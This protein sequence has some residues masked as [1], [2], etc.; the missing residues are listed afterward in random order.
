MKEAED[1]L[2]EKRLEDVPIVRDFPEV[3]LEDLPGILPT[4][5]VEF[6]IDL[7]LGATPVA[8]APY[9]L[10]PS[11][12][13]ELADQ[14]QELSDKGFIRPSFS[15]WGA[16]VLFV[17]K[18][19]ESFQMCIDYRELNKLTVKNRYPL[20][21]IDDLFDQL[22]GSSVYS[23]I[24]LRSGYHQLRFREEDIPKTAFRTRYGHYEFQVMPF[25]LT[26]APA[27]FMDLMNRVCKPYLDKFLIIFIDDILIYSKN[28]EDHEEHLKLILELLKK[29]E[30]YAKFS[31]C[32]FWIPKVQFLRHM[33][34]SKGIHGEKE[35]AE[36]QLIKKSYVAYPFWPCLKD[37]NT[38]LFI[39]MLRIK[40]I[41]SSSLTH[42][43]GFESSQ[44]NPRSSDEALKPENL[45]VEDVRQ[46]DPMEKLMRLY[47]KE[48]VTQHG[49]PVS[50]IS[51][52]DGRLMSLFWKALNEALEVGDAQLTGPEIVHET[53]EKIVQIKSRIQAAC[54]RQ[55]SYADLKRKPM[56]FQV[57]DRVILSVSPWKGVKCLPDE[58]L[59]ISLDGLRIDDKLYFV[60]EPV[61]IMDREIKQLKRSRILIIKNGVIRTK[62]YDELSVT[63]KIQFDCDM[64][65]INIILQGTSLTKQEREYKLYDAFDKFTHIKGESLHTYYLRFTQLINDI[66]IYK[67][68][69]EQFQDNKK[70]LNSLPSEWSK[71]VTDVKLVKNL[72][73]SNYD[74][75]HAYLK[76]HELH[77]NEVRLMREHNQDPFALVEKAMLAEAQEAGQMLDEEQLAFLADLG[78]PASQAQIII[79]HNAVFQIED[80]DTYDSDC[81]D[82]STTQAVLMANISNYGSDI[83]SEV[84][85]F[86][87]YLNDMDNQKEESR[88][89]MSEKEK[90]PEAIKQN[91]SL[92]PIDYEKL[93]RLTEYF[94]TR[95]TSQQEFLGE[96]AFWLRLSS[97]TIESSSTPPVKVEVPSELPKVS[98]VNK[99]LK[100]LKFQLTQFDSMVKKR[101]TPNALTEEYFKKNVLKAQ[102]QDKDT[103]ICKLKDTIK[104][105]RKNNKE[106]I[107]DH[108]RCVC[109]HTHSS[110][111]LVG[112]SSPNPTTSNLKLHNCRRSKQPFI[113]E[114]YPVDM[115]VNQRT[116]AELF[117]APIEGYA[118][119]IVVPPILAKHFKLKHILIN[120]MT[121]DQFFRLEKDNPHDHISVILKK[122]PEKLGDPRKF[123]IPCGYCELKCKALA[124]L[125]GKFTFLVD[126]VIVD[127]KS[128][129]R[130]SLFLGR[131]FL[132]TARALIDILTTILLIPFPDMFIDEHTLDY[133]SPPLY[134]DVDDDLV[135]LESDNGDV[136]DDL[137]DSKEDK[138]KESKL[139]IDELNPPRS[140]DFL[141]SPEY[142][143]VLCED[144]SKVDALP[145]TNKE[146]KV[147][148]PGI[149]IHENLSAVTVQ[150]I[151]DKNV[152]KIS[153]SNASLII[154][155][156]NPPLYELPFHKEVPGPP[157]IGFMRPFG[158]PVTI[159]NTLDSLGKF[160]GKVDEG[161]LVGY[162][163][164]SKAFR[165]FNS[166]TR[167]VQE[168]L[169]VNFLENKPNITGS[170]PT[171]LFDIDSLTRTM[172]YEPVSV[173]NQTNPSAS[174]QDKFDAEK[175]REEINQ[176]NVLFS[177]WSSGSTNPHNNDGDVAFDR[178][179]HDFDAKKPESGVILSPS[180]SA[181][182][183]KQDDKTKKEAKG[184]I[185]TV[186]QNTS[187]S[188]NP[189]SV[190]GPSN[191]TA[192]QTH[193]KSSFDASQLFDD[194]AMPEL[195]DITYSDDE[196]DVGAEADFNNLETSITVNPIP[197]TR[198]HKDHP[199]SQIIGDLS[200]TTQTRSM[201]RVVKD[202]GGLSQMFNDDFHTCMFACFLSQEEPKRV[203]QALKDPR[204]EDPDHPDKVY[205]VVKALYG[206]HQAPRAWYETL[207]NYLLE[208]GFQRGKIDQT[209]FIK[210]QKGDILLVKQK[211]DRI[212]ISQDKYVAEILRKFGL[213]EGK[214]ASTLIDTEKPLL[215]DPDGED[216]DVHTYRSMI[217][218]LMY[219]TSSRPD[220]VFAFWNSV[221]IKQV[222]DITRLQA[223]VDKKKVVV[224]EAAIREV[225]RL[226]D[227]EGVDCLPNEEIFTKRVGKGF[228][229]V[230][231]PLF[232]GMLVGQEIDEG[233]NEEVHVEDVTA[234]DVAQGEDT[235]A[236]GDV[237]TVSQEP[238]IPSPTPPT[239]SPQPPQ[240]L[241]SISQV[242][243]T[244][245]QLSQA[246]PQPQPQPQQAV[247]FP[248]SLFQ[249]ALDAC[250]AL[251]R[252][253][254]HL[255]LKRVGTSQ[256]IDTSND[257]VIDDESNQGRIIDEM[258]KDD[259]VALMDDKEEDK[260]DKEA[261][262]VKIDQVQGRQAES[263]A[264]IYRID[265]DYASKV[266]SMQEDEPAEVQEVVDVVTTAK[267]ITGVVTTASETVT[268]ASI[269]ISTVEPQVP[270]ATITAALEKRKGIMVEEP[271]P[272]K[273]KQQIEMGEEYARKLHAKI[274]KDIDWDVAIDHVKLKAKEDPALDYFKGMSHDDIRPIF[275]AKFNSNIEFFLKTKEQIEEEENRA[276]QKLSAAKQKLM[277]LDNAVE[278]RLMLL[279][280]IN[281]AEVIRTPNIVEHE[282]RAIIEMADNHT[283][284][285]LLQAPTEGY[286]E[287]IVIP[288]INAD[289][290]EIKMNLLQ[291]VQ[292]NLYHGFEREN[293]HT[294][295][296]D[297]NRITSTL[298]FR[299]VP[300][301]VIKLMM[302]LY[303]LKGNAR[304][305]YDKEPP[306]SILTWEDLTFGEAWERFKE[307]LRA[308]PHHG[309]TK[310][311]QIDTFCNG[312]N[313][314]D[315]DSLNA[316]AGGNLLSK[317]TREALQ[318]IKNK[319]KVHY[320]RNKADVSRMNT[321]FREN[322]NKLDDRIDKLE[323]KI[324]TLVDI[325]AKK[326]VAPAPVKVVEEFCVT[327]DGAHAYYNCPNTDSNQPT[328]C[329]ATGTYN[330]LAPQNR[331]NNFM[332]PPGFAL[333]Q[334]STSGTLPSNTIPNPKGE[335]K[336]I[337]TRSGVAYEG[338][339][340]PTPKKVV[341]QETEE[342]TDKEQTNFQ[343]STAHIQPSVTPITKPDV[344]KTLPKTN[345]P[346]PS[347][348]NDQKLREKT[349]NQM[350][351]FFQI[352]Q[353]LHF[354][355]SFA[356]ALILMTK[357]VST[358]KSL[359][360]N[361]DK[362]FEL[363]KIPLNENFLAMLLKK[364]PEK[365]GIL[366]RVA[367]DVFVKVG[368][369]HFPTDFIVV[370]FE[371]DPRVPLILGRSFLRIGSALIDVYGEEIILRVN[372]EAV[373]FNLNQTTRYSSTYDDLSVNRIDIMDV[374]REEY[375][376][377]FLGFSSN[378]SG[379][380]P[381]LTFE[382]ILSDSSPSLT[383]FEGSDFILEETGAYL[384][385]ESIS[386]K[387]DH[388][389][390]DPE[391]DI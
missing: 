361:K 383:P 262:V 90:D 384:K 8:R 295:I 288:E 82:L 146:D 34:D 255:E 14:L 42:D 30:L 203:H 39:V 127:D 47:L 307:I 63:E 132:Q 109:I 78:I 274:N 80:L 66:N 390:C 19:S 355:I 213:I 147:F 186:G 36:F 380:S 171:W 308:C 144:F 320:S 58:S 277:L 67:M 99:S 20:P 219:L 340:I 284:E 118:E 344:P 83:I 324:L 46:N 246:Q 365:L 302:F 301:D 206:L 237:L 281:A 69:M 187:N 318:I 119:A 158:Y 366:A 79:P 315:Q 245:P 249:E 121:S 12:M 235:A 287:A 84:P 188:T 227:A 372:D 290:F 98:L 102:L 275:E 314:N 260:K 62:K 368:K 177:V 364:L 170:G 224:T 233:E 326:I 351:K 168:T 386:P 319:S 212:F 330:Q 23:K 356:D 341:E 387:I 50:I 86:E 337:T 242:Q 346:Y 254:E 140:S 108:D 55:K 10:A 76:Q 303:S 100:K 248:M 156:F 310:L 139:L 25:G 323:D 18:K 218:S 350:E 130:V 347:R 88:S 197:I 152:K 335:M 110:S 291:L 135:E 208:N 64:K 305:W 296:N 256:R 279:S 266:L 226:D 180:S 234:S 1:K 357:F 223:L 316:L 306:N 329:V 216:V 298:K 271:K 343:G 105:L 138:I 125:V 348:L 250:A 297:F 172:N 153:I 73:T 382:P 175:A 148:N 359:L 270:A 322:A 259:D 142:D 185:L 7:V 48:V 334:S 286:G 190:V 181:Q 111:N 232:E 261:K 157:S 44:E 43:Y 282:L 336:A 165:V 141:P 363:A 9:R 41:T 238:S 342:T 196:N 4:R 252:R 283:M 116:M 122:L 104:Y 179:E 220:I 97:P 87:T 176:Q 293:P 101:T 379:G 378:S 211:K 57:G 367:E 22:Q 2:E 207:A 285:E 134:D 374:A 115:M 388:A 26:N 13:K 167:I 160:E 385:D 155:Y 313:D 161:F 225:L 325:F 183:R 150:V 199:V 241:P 191:T 192:S 72:H 215:K 45:S 29:E 61:E 309:F 204:F 15:H 327:C 40:T 278:A 267:L 93:N 126:F 352:F 113:L 123:L 373:T 331:A 231:T 71:F 184:K 294:H 131:P 338:P 214:S 182:S 377:E 6:Q 389:D 163:V 51:D 68:K 391:E 194:P 376:Q 228:S 53:T 21:R 133:S 85:N 317:T 349:T 221:A 114:E 49:V 253:V 37:Q 128:N 381:T 280:H 16:P 247:D 52:H 28:K 35:E 56:D 193:G 124:D 362:L 257:T 321:T 240:D 300:N 74:Q 137:Y 353:D 27:V 371:A 174:F 217:G 24:D 96:Q 333:N 33:I 154:E 328:V 103:T 169:H 243:H 276:L 339:S 272:L 311:A 120:M 95:F 164:N 263:Q 332:A 345:I 369:F 65:A 143:S 239:L 251:T 5:Q 89:K 77:A 11:E 210:K 91:I 173:G 159:L 269:I 268:A 222:N 198:I 289:H 32:G 92:K 205:K 166:R 304:V 236:Y 3:F 54:G 178:K 195:E 94:R 38:S 209:I 265:I 129:P 370:D 200:S 107:I 75:L 149:L 258:E 229:G 312:L 162:S 273:K 189:F 145:S 106:E 375:A 112:E 117:R 17:K 264:E 358:I 360:T 60:E 136:Y 299:D 31:K 292:A 59:V 70:F 354:D 201:T 230:D 202:Q 151:P 244:L 81:D